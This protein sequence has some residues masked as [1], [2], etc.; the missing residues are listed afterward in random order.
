MVLNY[1]MFISSLFCRSIVG[2]GTNP[3]YG[4]KPLPIQRNDISP[5]MEPSPDAGQTIH[6]QIGMFLSCHLVYK[7]GSISFAYNSLLTLIIY[8]V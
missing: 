5:R 8:Y 4:K 6:N 7:K 3:S 2:S 1:P